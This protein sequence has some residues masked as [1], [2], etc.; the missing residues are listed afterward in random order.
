[1]FFIRPST[2]YYLDLQTILMLAWMNNEAKKAW[3][4][5]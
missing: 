3:D 5:A 4:D 1:M 2:A